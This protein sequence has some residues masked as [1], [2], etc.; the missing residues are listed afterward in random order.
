MSPARIILASASPRRRQLLDQLGIHHEVVPAAIPEQPGMREVPED[1]VRRIAAEKSRA[2]QQLV[3]SPL[4]ILAADT[5]VVLNNEIL[6]KPADRKHAIDMLMRL[7]DNEHWVLSGVSLRSGTEHWEAL[8]ISKVRFRSLSLDEIE[9][10]WSSGEPEGKAGAYAIQGLGGL[11]I[12]HLSGSY[13]GVMGLP[14]HETA[15]LLTHIG[16]DP[17]SPYKGGAS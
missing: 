2:V 15:S 8:C 14:L 16:I 12:A 3:S 7:S 9:A 10:Y 17:L 13:S 11:F 5:E 1:Y 6:G 4:P